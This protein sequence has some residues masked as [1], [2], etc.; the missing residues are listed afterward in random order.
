MV[1][2]RDGLD[3]ETADLLCELGVF[4]CD[5]GRE[6]DEGIWEPRSGRA[7]HVHSRL[8]CWAGLNRLLAMHDAG[9][10]QVPVD[11]F[12]AARE[13]LRR[14]IEER[15]WN[16]RLGAYTAT[17]DGDELDAAVL[18][19]G[20]HRFEDPGSP[21][22]RST[23]EAIRRT[24]GAGNGLLYRYKF[25]P[26]L[27]REGAFGICSFWAVELLALADRLDEA[28]ALFED[29]LGYANDVGLY[30]EEVDPTTG[31]A[32]G[33]FPQAFTHVGLISAA[34]AIEEASARAV[35]APSVVE[36]AHP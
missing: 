23:Y 13:Q 15:G 12:R 2:H 26:D 27:G 36:E 34:L 9:H 33:N 6:P 11:K 14:D 29:L 30:A 31:A 21:R 28:H 7:N 17:L 5:H 19:M 8:L 24:L 4:I 20:F 16:P 1:W 22:L 18:L 32:L 3:R 25:Q 10:L 35:R